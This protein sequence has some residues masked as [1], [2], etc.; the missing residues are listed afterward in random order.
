LFPDSGAVELALAMD[1]A[2][3]KAQQIA[4]IRRRETQ[5]RINRGQSNASALV[6]F[7]EFGDRRRQTLDVALRYSPSF[8]AK[9]LLLV[10]VECVYIDG[11]PKPSIRAKDI[12]AEDV[13]MV[14]VYNHRGAVGL[15]DRQLFRNNGNDCGSGA[16]QEV[17]GPAG[18]QL[19]AVRPPNPVAVAFI[20]IWLK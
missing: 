20:Y 6:G 5:M 18:S 10:N 9:G 4:N 2:A 16:V 11:V 19:K 14:E 1:S 7:Q 8:L 15:T 13:S 3:T 17:F 12:L